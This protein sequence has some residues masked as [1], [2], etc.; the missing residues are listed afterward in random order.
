MNGSTE[1][2]AHGAPEKSSRRDVV[3]S[4]ATACSMLPLVQRIVDDVLQYHQRLAQLLPEHD[5]LRRQRQSLSWPQRSRRYHIQEEIAAADGRLQEA[6]AELSSLGVVLLDPTEGRVGFPTVVNGR[7]A[8]FSWRCGEDSVDHW[9]FP[10]ETCRRN[11][12]ANWAR[13]A[14]GSLSGKS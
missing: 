2:T 6:L 13:T 5:R 11:I 9:H 3:L 4:L 10:E 1:N 12:P 8:Y 14:E 7:F